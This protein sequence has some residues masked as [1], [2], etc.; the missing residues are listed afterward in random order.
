MVTFFRCGDSGICGSQQIRLPMHPIDIRS[1]S[2]TLG[3]WI[4]D[5]LEN[6]L[7]HLEGQM[8]KLKRQVYRQISE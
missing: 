5:S 4:I 8:V 2:I 1:N 3:I 6:C 7:S